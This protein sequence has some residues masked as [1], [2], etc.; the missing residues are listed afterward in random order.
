MMLSNNNVRDFFI[1][2]YRVAV[3]AAFANA[4]LKALLPPEPRGRTIVIGAG[5]GA[6][7][8]AQKFEQVYL[9]E[10]SS[11][12]V[13]TRYGFGTQ[14]EQIEIIE[15]AHPVPDSNSAIAAQRL[16]H[17]VR[18]LTADDT[19]IALITGGG[20]ALLA[21]PLPPMSLADEIELNKQLLASGAP[22]SEMNTIRRHVSAIKGGRLGA[23][24]LPAKLVSFL[25]SDVPGDDPAEVASG[26]TYSGNTTPSDALEIICAR[27]LQVPSNVIKALQSDAAMSADFRSEIHILASAGKSLAAVEQHARA[28]HLDVINLGDAVEG[29][30]REVARAHAQFVRE[31]R[32]RGWRGLIVSGGETTVTLRGNGKGGRN[33]EYLLALAIE[34]A[35]IKGVHCFAAD[36]DGIDGSE[37]NAGSF[38]DYAT[39]DQLR[40]HAI[41]AKEYLADNDSFTAFAAIDQ[42]FSPGPS[43][44]NV[45]DLRLILIE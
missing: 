43:G 7:Q 35:G 13:V 38:A 22:I 37:D 3:A 27:R 24:T 25:V 1:G 2:C 32:A 21:A 29:E 5:K 44:T 14:C 26:P 17:A 9:H 23:A 36:T 39:K 18:G 6:A 4:E 10:I 12:L 15:A 41:D 16:L 30:A 19:V 40:A 11:G 20:S 42:L 8:L 34:L 28:L 33:T 31:Q 45:N